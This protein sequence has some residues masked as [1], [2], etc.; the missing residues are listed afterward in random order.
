MQLRFPSHWSWEPK[1]SFTFLPTDRGSMNAASL[2][3]L[4]TVGTKMQLHFSS[5]WLW[6]H[7]SS[8]ISLCSTSGFLFSICSTFPPVH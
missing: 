7:K 6:E 5:Y 2:S 1:C 4:L 3:F 8:N